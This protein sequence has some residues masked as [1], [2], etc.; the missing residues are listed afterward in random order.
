MV[1]ETIQGVSVDM[2]HSVKPVLWVRC[3]RNKGLGY[4]KRITCI[5]QGAVFTVPLSVLLCHF[6]WLCCPLE[7][8]P[9]V[10]SAP[11]YF[12]SVSMAWLCLWRKTYFSCITANTCNLMNQWSSCVYSWLTMNIFSLLYS[13]LIKTVHL[14]SMVASQTNL[15]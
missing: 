7:V 8:G 15:P 5:D 2:Y 3:Y 10:K 12:P 11:G 6:L 14:L 4:K 13:F 1:T 9:Q